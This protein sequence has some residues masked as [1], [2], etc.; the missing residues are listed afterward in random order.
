MPLQKHRKLHLVGV[1][2]IGLLRR[3]IFGGVPFCFR[4][5]SRSRPFRRGLIGHRNRPAGRVLAVETENWR[6]V[7]ACDRPFAARQFHMANRNQPI[8]RKLRIVS[9][10]RRR[11]HFPCYCRRQPQIPQP[12]FHPAHA[13]RAGSGPRSMN[14]PTQT[15]AP[16]G[17]PSRS[18]ADLCRG[19]AE[20]MSARRLEKPG[21]AS[22]IRR[23]NA[24]SP[25]RARNRPLRVRIWFRLLVIDHGRLQ[26]IRPARQPR[27]VPAF[28]SH[29]SL[30][31]SNLDAIAT[32]L[33]FPRRRNGDR[34]MT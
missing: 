4:T 25:A 23:R 30:A 17:L 32:S 13:S 8:G 29:S 24:M 11:C 19:Q 21:P 3:I 34:R 20:P 5:A 14:L 10:C 26:H 9:A 6:L 15:P 7:A 16:A 12:R 28:N 18:P 1:D 27:V 2:L 33:H 22:P 31:Q